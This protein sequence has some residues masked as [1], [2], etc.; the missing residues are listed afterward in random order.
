MT[1]DQWPHSITLSFSPCS[2]CSS[3]RTP[4]PLLVMLRLP[5]RSAS[6]RAA[7]LA[8]QS[9]RS[10]RRTSSV[11]TSAI[12]APPEAPVVRALPLGRV[13]LA[14]QYCADSVVRAVCAALSRSHRRCNSISG[15]GSGYACTLVRRVGHSFRGTV[16]RD[17]QAFVDRRYFSRSRRRGPAQACLWPDMKQCGTL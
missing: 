7:P 3:R 10:I 4:D 17:T 13:C 1:R 11:T 5:A 12:A 2:P 14:S 8:A 6:V 15:F 9:V 16:P